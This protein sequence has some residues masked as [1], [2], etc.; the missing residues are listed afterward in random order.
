M[1]WL[2]FGASRVNQVEF[3]LVSQLLYCFFAFHGLRS[4]V[5]KLQVSDFLG[6]MHP[7]V[8]GAFTA[9]MQF[10]ARVDVFGVAC[11]EAAIRAQNDINVV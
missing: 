9:F 4:R 10:Y 8:F 2:F 5:K 11:I 1:G 6:L 3:L 7:R